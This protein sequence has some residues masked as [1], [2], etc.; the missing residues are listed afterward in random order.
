M[1]IHQLVVISFNK[2]LSRVKANAVESANLRASWFVLYLLS[3]S[4]VLTLA[5][6]T[7]FLLFF[8]GI[9]YCCSILGNA[10]EFTQ[11]YQEYDDFY[12]VVSQSTSLWHPASTRVYVY[13]FTLPLYQTFLSFM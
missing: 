10:R 9:L 8:L 5:S 12:A 1:V 11:S 3:T 4:C 13:V 2:I 7:L 6:S